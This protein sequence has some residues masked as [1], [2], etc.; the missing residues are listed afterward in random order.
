MIQASALGRDPSVAP[1]FQ[2]ET[3]PTA[4]RVRLGAPQPV[5]RVGMHAFVWRGGKQ[6]AATPFPPS[7]RSRETRARARLRVQPYGRAPQQRTASASG[8]RPHPRVL[9]PASRLNFPAFDGA[10]DDT[11]LGPAPLAL[12]T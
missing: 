5:W 1:I 11:A 6:P 9:G 3:P 12:G 8:A 2:A 10:R 7:V 4:G